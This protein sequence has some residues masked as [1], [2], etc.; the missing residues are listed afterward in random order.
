M[1]PALLLDPMNLRLDR[2]GAQVDDAGDFFVAQAFIEVE[3]GNFPLDGIEAQEESVDLGGEVFPD[4]PCLGIGL[5]WCCFAGRF[6]QVGPSQPSE[7][8]IVFVLEKIEAAITDN[9]IDPGFE[10]MKG[11]ESVEVFVNSEHHVLE[12]IVKIGMVGGDDV[13]DIK[14]NLPAPGLPDV[15]IEFF[16]FRL[17]ERRP[18]INRKLLGNLVHGPSQTR[19]E[20]SPP[21]LSRP[22]GANINA[23]PSE[24]KPDS[25]VNIMRKLSKLEVFCYIGSKSTHKTHGTGTQAPEFPG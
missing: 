13:G 24:V 16:L 18:H 19:R 25:F 20:S 8:F 4:Q 9:G 7:A 3:E 12:K 17:A 5:G 23:E 10:R 6:I 2:I 21:I 15:I 22:P 11:I 14:R 1:A